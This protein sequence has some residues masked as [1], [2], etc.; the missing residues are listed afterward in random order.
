MGVCVVENLSRVFLYE[1]SFILLWL[2]RVYIVWVKDNKGTLKNPPGRTFREYFVGRPYPQD[3][4][5]I[6]SLA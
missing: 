6:D 3:T 4:Y 1:W 5:E 2:M